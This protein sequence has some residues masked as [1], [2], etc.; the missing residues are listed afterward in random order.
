MVGTAALIIVLSVFNGF[1]TVV[2]RLFN[3]FNPEIQI[4]AKEGKTF[5]ITTLPVEKI[6]Q[7]QGVVYMTDAIEENALLKYK[8]KQF[9]ATIKG[10]NPDYQKLSGIDTMIA[11]GKFILQKDTN[12]YAVVGQGVAFNLGINLNDYMN[13]LEIYVPRRESN[14]NNPLEAFNSETAFPTGIFS[15]Q[16]DYDIKYVIIPLRFARKLLNYDKEVSSEEIG[17]SPKT[18]WEK[19]QA[20]IQNIAG[21]K[22][23]VKN[24]FQQQALLYKI[25]KSEK[26]AIVLILSFILLIATFNVVGTL[27]MLILDKKKDISILWSMGADRKLIRR[28]FFVEGMMIT[29]IGA[30]AGLVLG[31]LI[32]WLQQRF[33]L[34]R[35]PDS[36]SFVITAYPVHMQLIDFVYVLLIDMA[37]GLLVSWY[38][39]KQISKKTIEQE[40][41]F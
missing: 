26:W 41:K 8:D 30:L 5:D 17:L 4:T 32:C 9:I 19:I 7:I 13:P 14:F 36:G 33:G 18:D 15:V 6:R 11:E 40:K 22:F 12:N 34:I 2:V 20:Q 29:F 10:V 1:E 24:R 25:M 27:T 31:A 16:Q 38:P 28:I 23:S 37:I 21:E 3:T 35:M 39:V